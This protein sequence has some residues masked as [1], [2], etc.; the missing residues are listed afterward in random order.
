MTCSEVQVDSQVN[1]ALGGHELGFI[2]VY[3]D[4]EVCKEVDKAQAG[5]SEALAVS[6]EEEPVV[7][8]LER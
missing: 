2:D 4:A 7:D 5:K 8:V 3:D 6:G 1:E